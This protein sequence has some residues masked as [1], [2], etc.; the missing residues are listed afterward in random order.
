[1]E[2]QRIYEEA[3]KLNQKE[4]KLYLSKLSTEQKLLYTKYWNKIRQQ[5]FNEN[6]ENRDLYNE[7]RNN[8]IKKLREN[9]PDKMKKQNIKDVG[10]FRKKEKSK[11]EAINKK[12]NLSN[13]ITDVIK[14]KKARDELN[15]LRKEKKLKDVKDIVNE[16]IDI[17]PK[18]AE[19]KHK[20]EYM[21]EYRARKAKK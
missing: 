3:S 15:K 9:K 12:L 1:M 2:G 14:A 19:L 20:S 11:L 7:K 13:I 18:K 16:L 21:R 5:K 4:K 6:K 8:Y 10:N 17:I